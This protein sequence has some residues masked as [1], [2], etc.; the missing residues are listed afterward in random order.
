M[1]S[2]SALRILENTPARLVAYDP[3]YQAFGWLFLFF[4]CCLA[5]L[6]VFVMIKTH[7]GKILFIGYLP[8]L[9]FGVIGLGALLNDSTITLSR[10]SRS[11]VIE[12]RFYG[13]RS[14]R[15][16]I[17]LTDIQSAAVRSVKN[18]NRV[19]VILK[20]G[21]EIPLTS[22]TDRDG[23]GI[24]AQDINR[25]L[26]NPN[27]GQKKEMTEE[28]RELALSL[29]TGLLEK[30]GKEISDYSVS[31]GLVHEELAKIARYR[32]E[33]MS[34]FE[35]HRYV[36]AQVLPKPISP[37]GGDE[38]EIDLKERKIVKRQGYQRYRDDANHAASDYRAHQTS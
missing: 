14:S 27:A 11:L 21:E 35:S 22:A 28:E 33:V 38:V 37:G 10:Q 31:I 15:A 6:M 30:E 19:V 18:L 5:M 2:S 34:R 12:N 29:I 24:L 20:S 8:A 17:A 3:P 25:F 9:I 16:P 26:A 13:M 7:P 36:T 32:G 1:L 23:Y 4:G